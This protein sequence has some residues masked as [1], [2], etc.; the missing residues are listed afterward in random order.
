MC[1]TRASGGL[2]AAVRVMPTRLPDPVA[3]GVPQALLDAACSP[4]GIIIVSGQTGSGKT[5]V[6]MM[7][8]E[9]LNARS[10][11]HILTIE[12][13]VGIRLQ[14]KQA[15]I[16]QQSVGTD[17]PSYSAA[18]RSAM[19]QDPDVIFVGEVRDLVTLEACVTA[20][21][22]G[23]LVVTQVHASSPQEV[24]QRV[25]EVHPEELRA[26][27]RRRL[28]QTLRAVSVQKLLPLAKGPGLTA[29]FGVLI[30]DKEMRQAIA[31]G[32]N[33]TDRASALPAGCQNLAD[34]IRRLAKEGAVTQQAAEAALASL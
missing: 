27:F 15:V 26:P 2:T 4:N 30:P 8:L 9:H 19:R 22:T 33:V 14:P 20:A 32:R 21:D 12:D 24:I 28:A 16:R 25:V 31:D 6:A 29:A 3:V 34:D 7:L 1:V 11:V 10:P 23:H 13:P 17:T 5:T 18:L